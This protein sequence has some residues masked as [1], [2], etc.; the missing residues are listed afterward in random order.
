MGLPLYGR[1]WKLE[2]S[3][4]HGIGAPAV[5][6]G[7]GDKGFMTYDEVVNFNAANNATEVYDEMT[8]STYSYAGTDWIG[9]D[10]AKSIK[11][12]IDFAK[13]KCLEG[14]FFW[15]LGYVKDDTLTREGKVC[16]FLTV[17]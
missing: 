15:A 14:Y 9:Y 12:K 1:S 7:R 8:V 10:N 6:T 17:F 3:R 5:G 13:S 11:E 4:V 16:G 2:D